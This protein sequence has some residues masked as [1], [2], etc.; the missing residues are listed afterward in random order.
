M[1]SDPYA[2]HRFQG[3]PKPSTG[4]LRLSSG[5]SPNLGPHSHAQT[6]PLPLRPP[7]TS[8]HTPQTSPHTP[9]FPSTLPTSPDPSF[10][11]P[12]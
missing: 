11:N 1:T 4:A 10:Q 5:P 7:Q 12:L 9:D 8:P 2:N 6:S 3:F